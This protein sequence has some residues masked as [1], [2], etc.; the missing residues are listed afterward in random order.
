MMNP[1]K[2][3]TSQYLTETEQCKR[4]DGRKQRRQT[5]DDKSRFHKPL[6][7][8]LLRMYA[9]SITKSSIPVLHNTNITRPGWF[10]PIHIEAAQDFLR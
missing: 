6:I 3:Q 4:N 5:V 8:K 7:P 9:S 2:E 1:E 10:S